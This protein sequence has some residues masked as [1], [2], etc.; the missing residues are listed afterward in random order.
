MYH[1]TQCYRLYFGLS[2]QY[3]R[4]SYYASTRSESLWYLLQL[5]QPQLLDY[6]VKLLIASLIFVSRFGI[7][8]C[9]IYLWPPPY[10][11]LINAPYLFYEPSVPMLFD[12]P[13]LPNPHLQGDSPGPALGLCP[14]HR[15]WI[16]HK[17]QPTQAGQACGLSRPGGCR[18]AGPSHRKEPTW[19]RE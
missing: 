5:N 1:W 16:Q 17:V 2:Y 14:L 19:C 18:E 10:L 12:I 15:W 9:V 6:F 3:M 7:A 13:L 11:Y 8:K 4:I